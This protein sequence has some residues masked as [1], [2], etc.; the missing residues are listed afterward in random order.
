[1]SM[2]QKDAVLGDQG[3]SG[4]LL[5]RLAFMMFLQYFVQGAYLPIAS[6]Y[7]ERTLGFTSMQ[8]GLFVSALAIGPILAPFIVG[9]LVDRFFATERVMAGCHLVGGILMLLL[10]RQT[11]VWPVI[12]L[13]AVYSIL[14]VPTMM[15]TNSL[16]FQHLKE[17]E[18]EFPWI[19][20]CGTLGFIVPAYLIEL[21]W[22]Q[23]LT[24]AEVDQARAI[25]FTLSGTVG[26]AMAVY[27]LSLPHTPPERKKQNYAPG[28]VVRMLRNQDFLVLVVVSFLIAI[29]HQF[30]VVWYSPFMRD[31]LDTGGWGAYEQSISSIGQICELAV[32]AG[33]GLLIK[34]L[35][36]KRTMLL[37]TCA[38]LLRCLLFASVFYLDPPATGK[39][40]MAATGQALHGFCFGCFMAVG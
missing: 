12:I 8:V 27:C 28:I 6:V 3:S 5:G 30:V 40:V 23:G 15:L 16:A 2:S 11:E 38:Y 4:A 20:L 19:R 22:L 21:W 18:M 13:G 39:V 10:A 31:I 29:A 35:G 37:G 9:Q 24:G 1:M 7:V 36:F 33:L 14:Y 26:I 34:K 32:L 25:A 17:S